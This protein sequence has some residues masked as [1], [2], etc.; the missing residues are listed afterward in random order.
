[1]KKFFTI[2][3]TLAFGLT[4]VAQSSQTNV[5]KNAVKDYDGNSYD[6]VKIGEQVWMKS[7]LRTTHYANGTAIALGSEPSYT[8]AYRYYPNNDPK[9]VTTYGY[10]YNWT[11]AMNGARSSETNPSGVQGI[12]P[13]GWHLPSEAEWEQLGDYVRSQSRYWCAGDSFN[14]AKAFAASYGWIALGDDYD[15]A[16]NVGNNKS[17]NN[18]T[19]FSIVPAGNYSG[20]STGTGKFYGFGEV[21][22]FW[23]ATSYGLWTAEGRCL[24]GIDSYF[25]NWWDAGGVKELSISIRCVR[26]YESVSTTPQKVPLETPQRIPSTATIIKNAVTDYDENN[27]D[28]VQIGDQI[29]MASNLRTTH[30]ADGTVIALGRNYSS[31][32]TPLRY[33]PNNSYSNVANYGYLYNWSAVMHGAPSSTTNPSDVQ[34]ICPSGWHVPSKDE[35][36]QL[37]QYVSEQSHCICGNGENNIAKSLASNTGWYTTMD[38]CAIGNNQQTN[39]ATGFSAVPAGQYCQ[40]SYGKA[41]YGYFGERALFWSSTGFS[42][43]SDYYS[44]AHFSPKINFSTNSHYTIP[45]ETALSVRCV[46]DNSQS[47]R[48][49][50]TRTD[51]RRYKGD[52]TM[53]GFSDSPKGLS[54]I[55]YN[56]TAD[57]QYRDAPDGTRIFEG[58]FSFTATDDENNSFTV[59]GE[60]RNNKQVGD[61]IWR[62][63]CYIKIH[64]NHEGIPDGD[65]VMGA[66]EGTFK[67]G[68]LVYYRAIRRESRRAIEASDMIAGNLSKGKCLGTWKI[69]GD[70]IENGPAYVVFDEKGNVSKA[71]VVDRST[72]DRYDASELS[73]LPYDYARYVLWAV[74][75]RCFRSTPAIKKNL[76]H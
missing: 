53:I 35:W 41:V 18:A 32:T 55:S 64:F 73:G 7:N 44:L 33:Y 31:T 47:Y 75:R 65:F 20:Y 22:E 60:F 36:D 27:Y 37:F 49:H 62:G 6:A 28:A 38:E 52:F 9:N 40:D 58:E 16:C 2:I 76:V 21:A 39:N 26:D 10:L 68:E 72:G 67:D 42:H 12:C 43:A 8:K 4:V 69:Y 24:Q 66:T 3:L 17:A 63:G 13:N 46:K 30:Y 34:G 15:D 51:L 45:F 14:T 59:H 71:Y 11:A 74:Q 50:L 29:W 56:G 61:W 70:D 5:I 19:G 1:M 57:Y 48:S 23:S 54:S 25:G